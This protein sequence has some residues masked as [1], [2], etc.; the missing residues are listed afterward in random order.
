MSVFAIVVKSPPVPEWISYL[1]NTYWTPDGNTSWDGAKWV[2][3]GPPQ[4]MRI[5][6]LGTWN[7]GFEPTK[8]RITGTFGSA[9]T[10][11]VLD[12]SSDVNGSGAAAASVVIDLDFTG[13]RG[14]I[15]RITLYGMTNVTN[16][17]FWTLP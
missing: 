2:E 3:N 5:D 7:E 16:I 17:E 12:A 1:D 8:I 15:D 11:N 14:D 6:E 4:S 13:P 10:I 9:S